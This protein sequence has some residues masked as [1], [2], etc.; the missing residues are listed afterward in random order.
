M[1]F[2]TTRKLRTA[3]G[4]M[5]YVS[6]HTPTTSLLLVKERTK[7]HLTKCPASSFWYNRF[8]RGF[9]ER[10]VDQVVQDTVEVMNK[11]FMDVCE[12]GYERDPAGAKYVEIGYIA[13]CG[14]PGGLRGNEIFVADL[15]AIV[16][17]MPRAR[18]ERKY[19]HCPVVL[20]GKFKRH[21]D[22]QNKN[23]F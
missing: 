20:Q 7:P 19:L 8:S 16:A 14:W 6:I 3:F 4:N 12:N 11:A 2:E 21:W 10:V 18:Q 23:K 22:I 13:M 9:H 15:G 17:L 1:H 5:W